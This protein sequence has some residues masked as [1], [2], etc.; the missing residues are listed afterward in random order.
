MV[1]LIRTIWYVFI[2]IIFCLSLADD[3]ILHTVEYTKHLVL[4]LVI[5]IVVL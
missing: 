1:Q 2:R 3:L 4:I 5:D